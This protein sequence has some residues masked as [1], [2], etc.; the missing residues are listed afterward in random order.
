MVKCKDI[1][2]VIESNR[3]EIM[4]VYKLESNEICDE[5]IKHNNICEH[6]QKQIETIISKDE[7][8]KIL[9]DKLLEEKAK[10]RKLEIEL[11]NIKTMQNNIK[12]VFN[13]DHILKLNG[14]KKVKWS[15]ESLQK[16]LQART[17]IGRNGYEY[18]R[19]DLNLPLPSYRTLCRR[20]ESIQMPC[21]LQHE[22]L[23]FLKEKV[24]L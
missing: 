13:T 9:K 2:Y 23:D 1:D 21:S 22:L 19:N 20:I 17:L 3:N 12:T 10:T 7:V 11:H 14:N 4:S 5:N 16:S 15:G 24:M 8:T 18:L 6:T